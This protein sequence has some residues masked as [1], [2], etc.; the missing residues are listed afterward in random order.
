MADFLRLFSALR[1]Q[2]HASLSRSDILRALIWP[3]GILMTGIV[4]LVG[5]GAPHWLLVLFSALFVGGMM[6][7]GGAYLYCLIN[8]RDSLRSETY[9]LHKMA[10]EHGIYGD[11]RTGLIEP[12]DP[13]L[14]RIPPPPE[15]ETGPGN[16]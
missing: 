8:D 10:I 9:T 14:P 16:A 15:P 2:M 3:I 11:S 7:Y 12:G 5:T 6:L 4:G 13:Q 1:E